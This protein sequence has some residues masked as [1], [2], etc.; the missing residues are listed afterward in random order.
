MGIEIERKFLP[1]N[2]DW[3]KGEAAVLHIRQGY[4]AKN[5]ST[6]ATVRVRISQDEEGVPEATLCIKFRRSPEGVTPE[7]E[8]RISLQDAEEMLLRCDR[9]LEKRRHKIKI[10]GHTFQVDE[11]L[12]DKHH[13][14]VLI[15]VELTDFNESFPKP[16][17]LGEEKTEDKAYSSYNIAKHGFPRE[18]VHTMTEIYIRQR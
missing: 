11:F 16:P 17:W 18:A 5:K 7:F 6:G 2:E 8:D 3:K 9:V 13:G 10:K 15:E 4:I 12:G 14:G 1:K